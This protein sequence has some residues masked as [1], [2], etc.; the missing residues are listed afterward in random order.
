MTFLCH[1]L[2]R[3]EK[4]E[5][6][7]YL[8]YI[9]TSQEIWTEDIMSAGQIR[10]QVSEMH[11]RKGSMIATT[12]CST[13]LGSAFHARQ[14]LTWP[15]IW[16]VSDQSDNQTWMSPSVNPSVSVLQLTTATPTVSVI[17][18]FLCLN[19]RIQAGM[20]R[21]SGVLF[22]TQIC[23]WT[24]YAVIVSP[25]TFVKYSKFLSQCPF[26]HVCTFASSDLSNPASK[27]PCHTC[28]SLNT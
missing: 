25:Q 22:I 1:I 7:F 14:T 19:V 18:C 11:S 10:G 6:P 17:N 28:H 15:R 27:S 16:P 9:C 12:L 26:Y 23:C 24:P 21:C 8:K 2:Q 3:T 20:L 13:L 4:L 5:V